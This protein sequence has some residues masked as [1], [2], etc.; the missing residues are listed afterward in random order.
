LGLIKNIFRRIRGI[1]QGGTVV[2]LDGAWPQKPERYVGEVEHSV[3]GTTWY[4]NPRN[5]WSHGFTAS[6]VRV[7]PDD[8]APVDYP[9]GEGK[10]GGPGGKASKAMNHFGGYQ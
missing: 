7:T 8:G 10:P 4:T 5:R 1:P 9:A 2:G 6:A 3:Y